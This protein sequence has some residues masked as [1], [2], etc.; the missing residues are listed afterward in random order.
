MKKELVLDENLLNI[1]VERQV[2]VRDL[3]IDVPLRYK[4]SAIN[5]LFPISTKEAKKVIGTTKIKPLELF[6][7]RSFVCITLFDFYKGPVGKYTEMTLSIPVVYNSKFY[8]PFFSL[9]LRILLNKVAFFVFSVAQSSKIAIE[10]GMAITG[11]PRYNPEKLIDVDYKDDSEFV[12]A[13]VYGDGKEILNIKIKKPKNETMRKEVYDTYF[14]KNN[15]ISKILMG[16][17][18]IVGKSKVVD[19]KVGDHELGTLL[20]NLKIIPKALDTRYYRDTVK[21]IYSPKELENL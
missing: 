9:I 5:I 1:K 10:H 17:H 8:L 18:V 11:Y 13:R 20:K 4:C 14:V 21:I 16:T 12:Y 3:L 19:F 7:G 2:K 6:P 15:K